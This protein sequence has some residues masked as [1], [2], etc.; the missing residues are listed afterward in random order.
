[1]QRLVDG[2]C[3]SLLLLLVACAPKSTTEEQPPLGPVQAVVVERDLL[4]GVWECAE[5]QLAGGPP[6]TVCS[7]MRVRFR[8]DET[9]DKCFGE[10]TFRWRWLSE[11]DTILWVFPEAPGFEMDVAVLTPTVLVLNQ[12]RTR[13]PEPTVPV[14]QRTIR[15]ERIERCPPPTDPPNDVAIDRGAAPPGE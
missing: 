9:A 13:E 8:A 11:R 1:M 12:A 4:I 3:L 7:A 5:T 6:D 14:A 2:L 10:S 15:Y